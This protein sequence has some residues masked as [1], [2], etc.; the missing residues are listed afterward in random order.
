[1]SNYF[2]CKS[3]PYDFYA[4]GCPFEPDLTAHDPNAYNEDALPRDR[5]KEV[6]K[7]SDRR[8]VK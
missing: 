8:N 3:Y 4:D 2:G 1:M 7:K 5:D 6:Q